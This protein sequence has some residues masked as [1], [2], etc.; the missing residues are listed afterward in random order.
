MRLY[1]SEK[2]LVKIILYVRCICLINNYGECNAESLCCNRI[3]N[4][5]CW[6]PCQYV[7]IIDSISGSGEIL[8]DERDYHYPDG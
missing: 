3:V 1:F 7:R 6:L 8:R 5:L 2:L 4:S